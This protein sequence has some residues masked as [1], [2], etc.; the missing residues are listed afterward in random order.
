MT[1]ATKAIVL[2]LDIMTNF[3]CTMSCDNYSDEKVLEFI[4]N[5]KIYCNRKLIERKGLMILLFEKMMECL[6]PELIRFYM[7]VICIIISNKDEQYLLD[8][9]IN[10]MI[11]LDHSVLHHL[12][13]IGSY[14]NSKSNIL[15]RLGM[16]KRLIDVGLL[17]WS[18]DFCNSIVYEISNDNK[19]KIIILRWMI[20][21]N[22]ECNWEFSRK[23]H[24]RLSMREKFLLANISGDKELFKYFI[25]NFPDSWNPI[26]CND[27]VVDYIAVEKII[28]LLDCIIKCNLHCEWIFCERG[29]QLPLIDELILKQRTEILHWLSINCDE[30]QNYEFRDVMFVKALETNY[31]SSYVSESDKYLEILKWLHH[32]NCPIDFDI[33]MFALL[34]FNYPSKREII[35]WFAHIYGIG[36]IF[37]GLYGL[38]IPENCEIIEWLVNIYEIEMVCKSIH[39]LNIP[40]TDFPN[41]QRIISWVNNVYRDYEIEYCEDSCDDLYED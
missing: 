9:P 24:P 29:Y 19:N 32:N 25:E 30:L 12:I 36:I 17:R 2:K 13:F 21:N 34:D 37:K 40:D 1:E 15:E 23:F 6:T 22:F 7:G 33:V 8:F 27:I 16:I 3:E 20:E 38:K 31:S 26:I 28:G 39:K 10:Q 11:E 41:T 4:T 14:L 18:N 35:E 5:G